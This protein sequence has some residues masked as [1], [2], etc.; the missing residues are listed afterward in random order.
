MKKHHFRCQPVHSLRLQQPSTSSAQLE[1]LNHTLPEKRKSMIQR[2]TLQKS[3]KSLMSSG[4]KCST[5]KY[6]NQVWFN[7]ST[8][9]ANPQWIHIFQ[10]SQQLLKKHPN[11]HPL[12]LACL[13][14][15]SN[16]RRRGCT[17]SQN[18]DFTTHT[19]EF[20]DMALTAT[21]KMSMMDLESYRWKC[22]RGSRPALSLMLTAKAPGRVLEDRH[23]AA[24]HPQIRGDRMLNQDSSQTKRLLLV[25]QNLS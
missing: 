1:T 24:L 18:T 4:A 19:E 16:R 14:H 17:Q 21:S 7:Q 6:L 23:M 11:S 20:S 25:H 3:K 22:L 12:K 9:K 10:M 5:Q 2:S 15:S 8:P 13:N